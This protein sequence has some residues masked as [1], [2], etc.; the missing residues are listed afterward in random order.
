LGVTGALAVAGSDD[1]TYVDSSGQRQLRRL[2]A[3]LAFV[4]T[5][6]WTAYTGDPSVDSFTVAGNTLLAGRTGPL[7]SVLRGDPRE[8]LFLAG[9]LSGYTLFGFKRFHLFDK[10][11]VFVTVSSGGRSFVE[12]QEDRQKPGLL[13]VV[14][15]RKQRVVGTRAFAKLPWILQ[16]QSSSG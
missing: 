9:G 4:N 2:P 15:L 8:G 6:T 16:G 10:E 5:K 1:V 13:R 14:D 11:E 12:I 7:G 3:G